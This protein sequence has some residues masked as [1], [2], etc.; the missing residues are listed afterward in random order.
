MG[1]WSTGGPNH[2]NSCAARKR[3]PFI[4]Y[5]IDPPRSEWPDRAEKGRQLRSSAQSGHQS[6]PLLPYVLAISLP[7]SQGG[8]RRTYLVVAGDVAAALRLRGAPLL[9]APTPSSTA[10]LGFRTPF[11]GALGAL[12]C[13]CTHAPS[14]C[15]PP[16]QALPWRSTYQGGAAE[17]P[18]TS[19][20][21]LIYFS[22][23]HGRCSSANPPAACSQACDRPPG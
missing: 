12:V 20:R 14:F 10:L 19:W 3:R 13:I 15:L 8:G 11:L 17:C 22:F 2:Q 6:G 9:P 21:C 4:M 1:T 18:T 23:T 7:R 16:A 5:P